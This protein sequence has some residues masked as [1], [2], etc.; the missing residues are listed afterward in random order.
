MKILKCGSDNITRAFHFLL[1]SSPIF[2]QLFILAFNGFKYTFP[3]NILFFLFFY[4]LF[5][6][7]YL[8]LFVL[9]WNIYIDKNNIKVKSIFFQKQYIGETDFDIKPIPLISRISQIYIFTI[10]DKS[11][12]VK[13]KCE[14]SI[15]RHFFYQND[16][17][18]GIKEK[19]RTNL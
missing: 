8:K 3:K 4:F 14:F 5:F 16:T 1:S 17:M 7:F 9:D 12:Y 15:F 18:F 10:L 2:L 13:L 11:Y 19:I 6:L